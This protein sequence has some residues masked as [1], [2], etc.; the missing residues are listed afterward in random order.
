MSTR[1][2]FFEEEHALAAVRRLR[3]DGYDAWLAR[4]PFA[5]EDDAEDH[6]WAVT[7]DAPDIAL[8]LLVE[9]YDGWLDVPEEPRGL[10]LPIE[11][12]AAPRRKHRD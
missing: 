9:Q 4:E 6:P 7:T 12:P 2:I 8:D 11:L 10:T 3:H 5:G 1:G